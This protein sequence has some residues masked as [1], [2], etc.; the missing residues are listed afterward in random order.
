MSFA[1]PFR[2]F[3]FLLPR[4][5]QTVWLFGDP[6]EIE[7]SYPAVDAALR[8][9][10]GYR[11]IMASAAPNL[12]SLR[13]RYP[14]EIVLP[15]PA[16]SGLGRWRE[17]LNPRLLILGKELGHYAQGSEKSIRHSDPGLPDIVGALPPLQFP[18]EAAPAP[19]FPSSL[20]RVMAGPAIGGLGDLNQRLFVPQ[21]ILCLGNGPSSEDPRLK[22]IAYDAL[23]RVNWIWRERRLF[24]SPHM[25]FTADFDLPS[26]SPQPIIGFP[27]HAAGLP[28][29]RHYCLRLHPPRRGYA[30]LDRLLPIAVTPARGAT[31]TNGALM[32]AAAVALNPKRIIIAGID[33]YEHGAGRYPGD[34]E[35]VDGYSREHDRARDLA[36]IQSALASHGGE[37][38]IIGECLREALGHSPSAG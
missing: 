26:G 8:Q 27:S 35:A 25:V 30:F 1:D 16:R 3:G 12:A 18:E 2:R 34:L 23:F 4:C 38:I 17:K 28:I 9:R 24:T 7:A 31:P 10:L 37:T 33:L 29:L 36:L 13:K 19:G 6:D 14:H 5:A 20:I 32:I 15:L 21:T 22:D 11:L